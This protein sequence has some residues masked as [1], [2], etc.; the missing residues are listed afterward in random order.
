MPDALQLLRT[1]HN[2]VKELFKQFEQAEDSKTKGEIVQKTIMELEVH[3][4]IEEEIFY[5]ALRRQEDTDEAMLDEADEEH[6]VVALLIE[7]LRDMRPGSGR[8]DAK[9]K[10]LS[11]NVKHH[12]DEEES[13]LFPRAAEKGQERLQ[14][15]GARMEKRKAELLQERER[16]GTRARKGAGSRS[17]RIATP[18][19]RTAARRSSSGTR[20]TTGTAGRRTATRSTATARTGS[21]TARGT[22]PSRRTTATRSK[23]GRTASANGHT[24]AAPRATTAAR[25]AMARTRTATRSASAKRTT[26]ARAAAATTRTRTATAHKPRAATTRARSSR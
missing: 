10:V 4:Q 16:A 18:R 12:I 1:D 26:P 22:A 11:E 25:A 19:A 9:F 24:A 23:A 20:S 17:P 6:H 15:L 21:T 3:S 8:Y 14:L 2:G 7:E 13:E 5:P